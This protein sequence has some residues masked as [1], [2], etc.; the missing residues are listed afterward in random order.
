MTYMVIMVISVENARPQK[1]KKAVYCR[2]AEKISVTRNA[3]VWSGFFDVGDD[4]GV[5]GG[6]GGFELQ[7][8][9]GFESVL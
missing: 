9:L 5:D 8:E 1:A 6:F 3:L 2:H 7:A 4:N